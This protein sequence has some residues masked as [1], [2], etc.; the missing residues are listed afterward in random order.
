MPDT[1]AS[2]ELQLYA[3]NFSSAHYNMVGKTLSKFYKQG[4]YSHDRAIAYIDRYLLIPAAKDYKLTCGSMYDKWNAMFPKAER[5]L[6]AE[7]IAHEFVSE[8]K[9]G[10]L[11]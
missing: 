4:T 3:C 5:M 1:I 10:N 9:L 8:F 7:S 6:A 2:R 11:W